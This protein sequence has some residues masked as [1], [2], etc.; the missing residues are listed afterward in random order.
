MFPDFGL[1][2]SSLYSVKQQTT[3]ICTDRL[4]LSNGTTES[5]AEPQDGAREG[6]GGWD[7]S[8]GSTSFRKTRYKYIGKGERCLEAW[9]CVQP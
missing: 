6:N 2:C 3:V 7:L 8:R 5:H 4:C 1:P 9:K